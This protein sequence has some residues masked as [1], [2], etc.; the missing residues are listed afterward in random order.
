MT[1]N[2][3][4]DENCRVTAAE[5]RQFVTQIERVQ[6]DKAELAEL[7]KEHFAAAKAAGYEAAIIRKVIARRKMDRDELAELDAKISMY[8]DAL[9]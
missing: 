9:A 3:T 8:E 4:E 1:F 2:T 7:E 5:L 6:A